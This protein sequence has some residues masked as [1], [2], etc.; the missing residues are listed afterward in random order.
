MGEGR[1]YILY[2]AL[3]NLKNALISTLLAICEGFIKNIN[4]QSESMHQPEQKW[5][6]LYI[7][8]YVALHFLVM[9]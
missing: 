8:S 3:V 1:P 2:Y 4:C 5:A 6:Q 9:R 7:D